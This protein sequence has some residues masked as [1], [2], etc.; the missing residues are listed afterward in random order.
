MAVCDTFWLCGK[1]LCFEVHV[2]IEYDVNC[3]PQQ[4][5]IQES[6]DFPSNHTDSV[7]ASK[8]TEGI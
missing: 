4:R 5:L 2:V 8:N 3:R 6:I 7:C 1:Q